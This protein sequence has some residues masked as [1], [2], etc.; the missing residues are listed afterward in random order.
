MNYKKIYEALIF[1]AQNRTIEGYKEIHHIKPRCMGGSDDAD[2]LV[3]FTPE[4]HYLAH[5]L[6]VK[7][8]PENESLV[9]AAVMM[10]PRRPTNKMY[11]WLKRRFSAAQSRKQSG[12]GNS[13]YGTKWITNP[14][15]NENLKIKKDTPIPDGWVEGRKIKAETIFDIKRKNQ[16]QNKINKTESTRNKAFILYEK[17]KNSGLSLR[18]FA[19]TDDCNISQ[20]AL[21]KLFKK[22]IEEYSSLAQK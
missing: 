19:L 9:K 6:L 1:K 18:K 20:P 7:M 8:F 13:Q 22:Y 16:R 2:N 12:T 10:I 3:E 17:Y 11:G 21:T 5:Q 14:I 15:T 4:E